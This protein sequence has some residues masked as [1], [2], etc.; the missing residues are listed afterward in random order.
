VQAGERYARAPSGEHVRL[1]AYPAPPS[2]GTGA[3]RAS[4]RTGSS[5]EGAPPVRARDEPP[6]RGYAH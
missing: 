6:A 4:D 2:A 3:E 1:D 5:V